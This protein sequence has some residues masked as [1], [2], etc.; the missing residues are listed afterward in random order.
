MQEEGYVI[1]KK[2]HHHHWTGGN[3]VRSFDECD[4]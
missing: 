2:Q 3:T 1:N 4:F